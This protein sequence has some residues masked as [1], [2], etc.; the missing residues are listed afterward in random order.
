MIISGLRPRREGWAN[1]RIR[2]RFDGR[3]FFIDTGMLSTVYERGRASA[4]EISGGRLRALYLDGS[5]E[6]WP[7]PGKSVDEDVRDP[8]GA[9]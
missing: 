7:R 8:P 1:G 9:G 3:V 4:L 5:E 6:L 2:D